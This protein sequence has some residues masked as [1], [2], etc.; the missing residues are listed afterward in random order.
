MKYFA[1]SSAFHNKIVIFLSVLFAASAHPTHK[2]FLLCLRASNSTIFTPKSVI[3]TPNDSLYAIILKSSIQNP[4][5]S[6]PSTPKPF[7]IITPFHVSHVQATIRCSKKHG[8]QVRTRSG[9][10]DFEGLSYLSN[11]PFVMIDLRNLSS[12]NVDVESQTAWVQAGANLGELYY[13][14][15][16]KSGNLGF[17]AGVCNT[18]GVG[19]HFSGG[20]H[21]YLSRKYGLAADNIV[22]AQLI[23]PQARLLDR[24][25]MGE[26]LF[27]AIRGG[28]AASFGIVLAWKVQLVLV[29]PTVTVFNVNRNLEHDETKKLVHRWQH[30]ANKVDDELTIFLVLRTKSPVDKKGSKKSVL[31]ASF[32]AT[33]HGGVDRL[34]QLMQKQ[35][36][37]LGLLR[38]ECTK[39]RWVESFLYFNGFTNGESLDVLLDRTPSSKLL[40][41]KAKSDYVQ[42]PI[43]CDVLERMLGKLYEEEVGRGWVELFPYGGKMNEISESAIPFPHRS[44]NLYKILYYAEWEEEGNIT[45]SKKHVSWVRRLYDYM[46][47]YVSKNPRATYLNYKDLDL[48]INNNE[49]PTTSTYENAHARI[50]GPMYFK[51]NFKRLIHVKS[52]VDPT[53][54]FVNEQSIPPLL[55]PSD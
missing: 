36:P 4:R 22:D 16:E 29:P 28:G 7:V 19:G 47:P 20:G 23:D 3:Y 50:W 18:V 53:N 33:F 26:D 11:V 12:I 54:F 17:P 45:T 35:F 39:M 14:I 51:D 30:V 1:R 27:W 55:T 24:K 40:S 43:P 34:L 48:G 25:S 10:H 31:E 46:T 15:A 13:R 41:F 6:S 8:V 37:E 44:G 38:Q 21:G 5:F 9:G 32:Q 49:C 42:E 52:I 2:D